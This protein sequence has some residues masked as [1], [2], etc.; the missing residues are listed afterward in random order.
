M[1]K[2]R[3]QD[4]STE[5]DDVGA[6]EHYDE[7]LPMSSSIA[8]ASDFDF[9]TGL[10]RP[11]TPIP[12]AKE[13]SSEAKEYAM[14]HCLMIDRPLI[15]MTVSSE[16]TYGH[17]TLASQRNNKMSPEWLCLATRG[18]TSLGCQCPIPSL[19]YPKTCSGELWCVNS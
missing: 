13:A 8:S 6:S 12:Y 2:I 3:L 17:L 1:T 19:L 9:H 10:L 5:D 14:K 11:I 16:T 4:N 15:G 18:R 7:I